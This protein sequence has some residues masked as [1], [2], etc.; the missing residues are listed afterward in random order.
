MKYFSHQG[1]LI[2]K[3][4]EAKGLRIKIRG[5]IV[6]LTPHQEEM[7]VAWVKKLGT[8]YVKDPV[9]IKNFFRDF[10]EALGIKNDP[11]T[12]EDIDFTEVITLVERERQIKANMP[13]EEKEASSGTKSH[14]RS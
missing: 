14:Q 5:N 13:K 12:P 2:P 9:F 3:R 8:D 10:T 1:V 11:L 6:A 4:Y 7:A